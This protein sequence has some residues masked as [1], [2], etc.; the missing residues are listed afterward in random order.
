M[1]KE[2]KCACPICEAGVCKLCAIVAIIIGVCF[3]LQDRGIWDFWNLSWYTVGFLIIGVGSL[4]GM[5][6]IK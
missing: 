4:I 3:L 6:K 1:A 2:V 5:H